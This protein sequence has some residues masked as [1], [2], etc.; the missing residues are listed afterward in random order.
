MIKPP[1]I[2]SRPLTN[3]ATRPIPTYVQAVAARFG[4]GSVACRPRKIPTA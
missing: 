3:P 2:P 1:P 4:F